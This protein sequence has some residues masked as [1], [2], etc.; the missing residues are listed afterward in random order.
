MC[1][2]L[3]VLMQ[4]WSDYQ[5]AKTKTSANN[6]QVWEALF[7]FVGFCLVTVAE[8]WNV[9]GVGGEGEEVLW[10][11]NSHTFT[12]EIQKVPPSA[13]WHQYNAGHCKHAI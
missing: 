11:V 7:S 13:F 1:V 10:S 12:S 9:Q 5:I 6:I 4:F 2:K 8:E 3:I